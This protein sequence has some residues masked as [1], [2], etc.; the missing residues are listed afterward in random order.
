LF[1]HY[2]RYLLLP[3]ISHNRLPLPPSRPLT[4]ATGRFKRSK[5]LARDVGVLQRF[6]PLDQGFPIVFVNDGKSFALCG[7]ELYGL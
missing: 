3:N 2:H 4:I 6:K 5:R 1:D 7:D